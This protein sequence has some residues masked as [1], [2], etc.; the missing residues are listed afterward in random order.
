MN[1][2]GG[3]NYATRL[4][5]QI[6]IRSIWSVPEVKLAKLGHRISYLLANERS[7]WKNFFLFWIHLKTLQFSWCSDDNSL[8]ATL[9]DLTTKQD[10]MEFENKLLL[11]ANEYPFSLIHMALMIPQHKRGLQLTLKLMEFLHLWHPKKIRH[12]SCDPAKHEVN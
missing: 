9:L 11:N 6:I 5:S 3:S 2:R 8:L 10:T 4:N 7:I 12:L 1:F